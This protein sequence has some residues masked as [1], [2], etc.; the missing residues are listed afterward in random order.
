[1]IGMGASLYRSN[2]GRQLI[3]AQTV[4]G[5][6]GWKRS[7]DR[8]VGY[9]IESN[10]PAPEGWIDAVS[11]GITEPDFKIIPLPDTYRLSR[12]S[13]K[14]SKVKERLLAE[15]RQA[16]YCVFTY[17]GWLGDPGEIAASIAR[18]N[19]IR[20]AVWLDRVESQVIRESEAIRSNFKTWIKAKLTETN[21]NRAVRAATLSLLHG[22]TVYQYFEKIA[23]N[24][25]VV[26]DIHYS[27][28]DRIGKHDLETK[29][30]SCREDLLKIIYVGRAEPM[31]GGKQWL[32]VLSRLKGKGVEFEASWY[33]DGSELSDMVATARSAGLL[34]TE[35]HFAGFVADRD[36][37][38]AA[39]RNAHALLFCH[40]TDES[41]R[42]LIESLHAATPLI[43][44]GDPFAQSLVGEHGGGVLVKR[45]QIAKLV[46]TISALA[47]NRERL[48]D[49]VERAAHSASHLTH[50]RVFDERSNVVKRELS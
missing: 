10:R 47:D 49:L 18:K 16:D 4:S 38:K 2:D 13:N 25:H 15:M 34:E 20:H 24:P 39:Y 23:R 31:K 19:G 6:K 32:E 14:I 44:Y 40:L 33:G 27:N 22:A 30:K 46:D 42:N 48:A 12:F 17:G 36:T 3:E 9:A 50:E 1:M 21:E 35:V 28:G 45:G 26:E 43:G 37:I 8:V 29:I 7:F 41:P 11:N 5:L